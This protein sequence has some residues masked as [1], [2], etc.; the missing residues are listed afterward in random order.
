MRQNRTSRWY[1]LL[2]LS[3]AGNAW[4]QPAPAMSGQFKM[5]KDCAENY[6]RRFARTPERPEDIS[7]AATSACYDKRL[8]LLTIVQADPV[9]MSPQE[10]ADYIARADRQ[11]QM[12][13]IQMILETRYPDAK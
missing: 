2:L 12:N 9:K 10:A 5:Y 3:L 8:T 7:L 6:G 11:V 4:S 13:V 1:L